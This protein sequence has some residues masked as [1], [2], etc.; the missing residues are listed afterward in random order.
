MK[1]EIK[2]LW[3]I[4]III[5]I[6]GHCKANLSVDT[7][8]APPE[9]LIFKDQIEVEWVNFT[10]D[11]FYFPTIDTIRTQYNERYVRSIES[12]GDFIYLLETTIY[13]RPGID[14]DGFILRKLDKYTGKEIWAYHNTFFSGNENHESFQTQAIM[15]FEG[16]SIFLQG[17]RQ[18]PF[19]DN[20]FPYWH[21]FPVNSNPIVYEISD[22]TG[23]LVNEIVGND[24]TAIDLKVN[25]KFGFQNLVK[26]N[27]Q[28]YY[29]YGGPNKKEE[30]VM[31][32]PLDD[33]LEIIDTSVFEQVLIEGPVNVPWANIKP[34]QI[35]SLGGNRFA[36]LYS[37]VKDW[38]NI[39]EDD[40]LIQLAIVDLSDAK[41]PIVIKR[42]DLNQYLYQ[43]YHVDEIFI[44]EINGDILVQ[45][46]YSSGVSEQYWL[47][48]ITRDGEVKSFIPR[49]STED[50]FYK[51]GFFAVHVNALEM[52][53]Y[54]TRNGHQFID[55]LKFNQG[56]STLQ[57][58]STIEMKKESERLV[59][60]SGKIIDDM[61][62]LGGWFASIL[63]STPESNQARFVFNL[64]IDLD[65]LGIDLSVSTE[66]PESLAEG[67][68]LFP[69][70]S[71]G[72]F[73]IRNFDAYKFAYCKITN[74][75]GQLIALFRREEIHNEN[76]DISHLDSGNYF[77]NFYD[78]RELQ[79][80]NVVRCS[81]I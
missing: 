4:F 28:Y 63:G 53:G 25:Y 71:D 19:I 9:E 18:S 8:P 11:S 3:T 70:P 44:N 77:I 42:L 58:L 39:F 7:I 68:L 6:I 62:I 15:K 50:K 2:V 52:I 43:D 1:C 76:I 69:N 35:R 23:E 80:Y 12:N 51:N 24:T 57:V 79:L 13:C 66:E 38:G 36:F 48:W 41:A 46:E 30:G 34:M 72:I 20:D 17:L 21:I 22:L 16:N 14:P 56:D 31:I 73:Y 33:S 10:V 45:K 29:I 27:D 26:N 60:F 54:A 37:Y 40:H 65:K 59:V 32:L 49:V 55:I 64:G 67:P 81:K 5:I 74:A 75:Q 78:E 47:L 61:L